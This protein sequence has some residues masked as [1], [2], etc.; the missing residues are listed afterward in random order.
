[1]SL[2]TLELAHCAAVVV[3]YPPGLPPEGDAARP[4]RRVLYGRQKIAGR[5]GEEG[6]GG[7]GGQKEGELRGAS[8]CTFS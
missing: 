1:M 4:R 8:A 7:R 5:R 3:F 2:S 6:K